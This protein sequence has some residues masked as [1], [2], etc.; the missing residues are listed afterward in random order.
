MSKLSNDMILGVI[1]NLTQAERIINRQ[2]ES[3]KSE[4][5]ITEGEEKI[6]MYNDYKVLESAKKSID[7][8]L[9]ELESFF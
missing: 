5:D 1:E 8:A 3:V 9:G 7:D 6:G 4:I 2:I